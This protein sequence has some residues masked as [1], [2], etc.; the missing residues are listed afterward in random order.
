TVPAL[1]PRGLEKSPAQRYPDVGALG[2]AL[3]PFG[4]PSGRAIAG[5]VQHL[6]HGSLAAAAPVS[7]LARTAAASVAHI[8][9]PR[10]VA[11]AAPS[12]PPFAALPAPPGPRRAHAVDDFRSSP[13]EPATEPAAYGTATS[14]LVAPARRRPWWWI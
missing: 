6:L 3:A 5:M 9:P 4:G 11:T 1:L 10:P 13:G 14:D 8:A 7:P 12:V 2:A